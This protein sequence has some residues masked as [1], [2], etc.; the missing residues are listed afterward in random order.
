MKDELFERITQEMKEAAEQQI[1]EH[2]K[3]IDYDTREYPV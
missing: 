2:H 3:I 1:A